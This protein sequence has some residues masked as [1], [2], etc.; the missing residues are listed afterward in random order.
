MAMRSHLRMAVMHVINYKN[1]DQ[2]QQTAKHRRQ[3][4]QLS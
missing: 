1:Y 2:N 4:Y 3:S